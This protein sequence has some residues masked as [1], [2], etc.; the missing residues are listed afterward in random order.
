MP[1][2]VVMRWYDEKLFAKYNSGATALAPA[3]KAH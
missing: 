1:K 2:S 3:G